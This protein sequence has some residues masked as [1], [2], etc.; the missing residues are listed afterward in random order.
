MTDNCEICT[1]PMD[2]CDCIPSVSQLQE[3]MFQ[4][5]R[6]DERRWAIFVSGVL[7]NNSFDTSQ[8]RDEYL[9]R[10]MRAYALSAKF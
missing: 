5:V 8:Q 1:K 3:K 6:N 2:V 10:A 4:L 7:D 9:R